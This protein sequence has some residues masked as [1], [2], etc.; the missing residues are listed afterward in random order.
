MTRLGLVIKVAYADDDL[1]E[2]E[3]SA[4]N[5]TFAGVVQA[6]AAV[7]A[8]GRWAD[9]LAGFP[10]GRDDSRDLVI[11]TFADDAAG[12]GAALHFAVVDGA[13]HCTLVVRLRADGIRAE[14]ASAAFTMRVEPAAIDAFVV[15]LRAMSAVLGSQAALVCYA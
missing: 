1:V 12:G 7:D 2:V 11:G 5:G 4:S 6:Y 8:P 14:P 15:A 10:T 9:S 13:G 3:V